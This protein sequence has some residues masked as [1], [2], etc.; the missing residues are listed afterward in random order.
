MGKQLPLSESRT[1]AFPTAE[2][3]M[4]VSQ[5]LGSVVGHKEVTPEGWGMVT[6]LVQ[7][8]NV[9]EFALEFEGAKTIMG[10]SF[11]GSGTAEGTV[12]LVSLGANTTRLDLRGVMNI[13][14]AAAHAPNFILNKVIKAQIDDLYRDMLAELGGNDGPG[15]AA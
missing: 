9:F 6:K 10:K 15:L 8:G 14:G 13:E 4:R 7:N 5:N 1:I 2:I 3:A 12:T 11:T